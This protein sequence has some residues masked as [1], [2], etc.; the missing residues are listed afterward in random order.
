MPTLG[1][2]GLSFLALG[3]DPLKNMDTFLMQ[4]TLEGSELQ[5]EIKDEKMEEQDHDMKMFCHW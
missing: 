4:S 1:W 3:E 5:L 2:M